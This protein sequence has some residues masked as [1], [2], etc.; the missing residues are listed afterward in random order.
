[1][2]EKKHTFLVSDESVNSYGF[3]VQTTGIDTTYFERNPVMF[4][5]HNRNAQ[6][7]GCWENLRK[8]GENLYADAVFDEAD[9]EAQRIAGKVERGFIKAASI[10]IHILDQTDDW[11]TKS[12]LMEIDSRYRF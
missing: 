7:I 5:M 10:G 4:Y 3:R 9:P 11:V 6:V 1:M 2:S 8:E 12:E